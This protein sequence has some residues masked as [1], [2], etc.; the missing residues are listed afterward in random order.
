MICHLAH[1]S[2]FF[3]GS[4][5]SRPNPP[6]QVWRSFSFYFGADSS[7]LLCHLCPPT[8]VCITITNSLAK[9]CP[10]ESCSVYSSCLMMASLP[11]QG[12]LLLEK[13]EIFWGHIFSNIFKY[14]HWLK[15]FGSRNTIKTK[16]ESIN[17]GISIGSETK[18]DNV[19]TK[20]VKIE[21]DDIE[22]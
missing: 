11:F 7:S 2:H 15:S 12:K 6:S 22:L 16:V 14:F 9:V 1:F 19:L 21:D 4:W 10:Q 5:R 3:K 8:I 18:L 20:A 13:G 17:Q